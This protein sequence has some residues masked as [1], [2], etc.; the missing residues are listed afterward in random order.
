MAMGSLGGGALLRAGVALGLPFLWILLVPLGPAGAALAGP[1]G[2]L[3]FA[4]GHGGALLLAGVAG[5]ERLGHWRAW[6]GPALAPVAVVVSALAG[7]AVV[8]LALAGVVGAVPVLAAAWE[9]G[10]L[11]RVQRALGVALG[12]ALA[13]LPLLVVSAETDARVLRLVGALAG[14]AVLVQPRVLGGGPVPGGPVPRRLVASVACAY[15]VGGVTYAVV[16][17]ALG[18]GGWGVAPYLALL[19]PAALVSGRLGADATARLGLGAWGW[20]CWPGRWGRARWARPRPWAWWRPGR[21]WTWG[22]GRGWGRSP[23]GGERIRRG[24]GPWCSASAPGCW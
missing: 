11:D 12:A 23:A 13:N 3:A 9:L 7:W 22:S 10:R 2:Q 15:L 4:L 17:P 18:G 5:G 24:W 1:R 8:G 14:V 19:L 16:L 20:G 21:S 6:G